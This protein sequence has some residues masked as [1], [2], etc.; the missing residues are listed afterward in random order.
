[1][2]GLEL[3]HEGAGSVAREMVRALGIAPALVQDDGYMRAILERLHGVG[4]E[5]WDQ[6][7]RTH[8]ERYLGPDHESVIRERAHAIW[9]REGRPEGRELDH[10]LTAEREL[11][12]EHRQRL[13]HPAG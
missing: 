6:H 1:M 4:D 9:E 7:F 12:D 2:D 13:L 11:R 8:P 10:W 3:D 5:V